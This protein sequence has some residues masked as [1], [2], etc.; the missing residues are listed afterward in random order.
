MNKDSGPVDSIKIRLS[1]MYILRGYDR[2]E[3]K[4]RITVAS[5]KEQ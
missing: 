3:G 4:Q 1:V 2:P 5:M